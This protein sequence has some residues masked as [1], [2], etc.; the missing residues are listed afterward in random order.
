MTFRM[1]LG[2]Y[3]PAEPLTERDLAISFLGGELCA[4]WLV[5]LRGAT[6][7]GVQQIRAY[8]E[9]NETYPSDVGR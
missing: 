3:P 4:E 5:V 7:L 9:S 6:D 1:F 8:G 2:I